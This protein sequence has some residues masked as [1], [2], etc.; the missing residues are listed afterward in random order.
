MYNLSYTWCITNAVMGNYS[1]CGLAFRGNSLAALNINHFFLQ[2]P[3][4]S[5][6]MLFISANLTDEEK[7][8]KPVLAV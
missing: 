5:T 8:Q 3:A 6:E 2:S 4:P 7:P 1:V